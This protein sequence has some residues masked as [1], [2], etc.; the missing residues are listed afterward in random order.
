MYS[1]WR[2]CLSYQIIQS[3]RSKVDS[4]PSTAGLVW[5][6]LVGVFSLHWSFYFPT[7][8]FSSLVPGSTFQELDFFFLALKFFGG[9]SVCQ[10]PSSHL[11]SCDGELFRHSVSGTHFISSIISASVESLT[12]LKDRKLNLAVRASVSTSALLEP[13]IWW[14]DFIRSDW[15]W[16]LYGSFFHH[17]FRRTSTV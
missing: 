13:L 10:V 17:A 3:K 4:I 2:Q 12:D 5:F 14:H 8:D 16:C 15:R 7:G 1:T 6:G 9:F 11:C